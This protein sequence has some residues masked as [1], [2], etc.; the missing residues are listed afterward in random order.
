MNTTSS[1]SDRLARV[2]E[3]I[4]TAA[5][6]AGRKAE[7]ILLIGASKKMLPQAMREAVDGGLEIFGEN[8]VQEAREKVPVLPALCQWHFIGG[9]QTNKTKEAVQLFS[10]I[11]SVDRLELL[12]EIEKRAAQ[13][14]K[15]MKILIEINVAGEASKEGARPDEAE[16]LVLAAN[17]CRSVEVHGLMTVAPFYEDL[18]EVRPYLEKLRQL[19]DELE[20]NTGFHLPELSMGMSHDFETAIEEGATMVRIGTLLFGER[21]K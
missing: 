17:S 16:A 9:L 5:S 10:W 1:F 19:R 14:G 11:H 12:Q 4:A 21:K 8:R 13:A 3:K 6:R 7:D 20:K 15:M 2:Q 18:E